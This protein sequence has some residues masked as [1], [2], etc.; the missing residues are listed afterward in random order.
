MTD[1]NG[2]VLVVDD[3][4]PFR[5]GLSTLLL[6][7]G[8]TVATYSSAAELLATPMPSAPCCLLLDI[9]MPGM[10]GLD[11]QSEL[12][13]R[14]FDIPII[15]LT[16]HADVPTTVRAMKNGAVEF[17]TKPFQPD[18]LLHAVHHALERCRVAMR[19]KAE[20]VDLRARY[21]TLSPPEREVMGLVTR[22]LLNKQIAVELHRSE[23]TIKV[24]RARVMVKMQA[25]SLA[26]LVRMGDRLCGAD[27]RVYTKEY[28]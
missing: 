9:C 1:R 7:A 25:R 15:F 21:A 18:D 12:A 6:S 23:I 27:A 8:A 17:L 4:E 2:I 19:D 3:N 26:D 13:R 22:G 14:G 28:T 5:V 16:G 24:H 10:G 20:F 11:L